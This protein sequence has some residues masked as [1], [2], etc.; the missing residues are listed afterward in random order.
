M[1]LIGGSEPHS[2]VC[3]LVAFVAEDE[4]NLV[5]N[6]DREAA[7]HGVGPG[8]K[9]R[10][11]VEHECMR[12]GFALFDSEKAVQREEGRIATGLRHGIRGAGILTQ[13]ANSIQY[14][15]RKRVW[16]LDKFHGSKSISP[17]GTAVTLLSAMRC[18]SEWPP[19]R[20]GTGRA[21]SLLAR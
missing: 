9:R 5:L 21:L 1:V 4:D 7:E 8:R 3:R 15:S 17:P 14:R 12:D 10:D 18:R 19:G 16:Y 13:A 11:G 20:N 2:V 6:V